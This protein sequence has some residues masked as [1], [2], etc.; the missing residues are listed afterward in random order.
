MGS[1]NNLLVGTKYFDYYGKIDYKMRSS[2][3]KIIATA[4]MEYK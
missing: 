1:F 3:G 2:N 4:V